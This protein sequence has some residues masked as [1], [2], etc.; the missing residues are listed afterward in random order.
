MKKHVYCA[1][2]LEIQVPMSFVKQGHSDYVQV[3]QKKYT[4][5]KSTISREPLKLELLKIRKIKLHSILFRMMCGF[6]AIRAMEKV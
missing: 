4:N 6:M 1:V 2:R 3:A 5:F